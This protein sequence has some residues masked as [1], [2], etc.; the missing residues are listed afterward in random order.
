MQ[1]I[2]LETCSGQI[3]RTSSRWGSPGCAL[4]LGA[5]ADLHATWCWRQAPQVGI[6]EYRRDV[7]LY[8]S[9]CWD[10]VQLHAAS[11]RSSSESDLVF[12]QEM[13]G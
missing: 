3:I 1:G 2:F 6:T 7:A 4:Q 8:W 12:S 13:L 5:A 9:I 10:Y 11:V